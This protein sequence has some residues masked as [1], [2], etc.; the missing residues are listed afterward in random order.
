MTAQAGAASGL[1][2][3]MINSTFWKKVDWIY[4][5]NQVKRLQMRIAKAM[6][7]RRYNKVKAL[8]RLLTHSL[9]AKL[10]A[11]KRVTSSKGSKTPGIDQDVW[12]TDKQKATAVTKLKRRGYQPQALRRIYIPKKNGKRR[13]ISIPTITCRAQQALHQLS[14]GPVVETI[15]DV[16]SYGFRPKRSCIDAKGQCFNI[17]ARKDRAQWILECDIRSAFDRS[18]NF[19]QNMEMV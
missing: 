16:N 15:A 10:L 4:V 12:R 13:P 17:F 6:R 1:N 14:L 7:E 9:Y 2:S 19:S 18:P 8:Q 5:E 11:V 3:T